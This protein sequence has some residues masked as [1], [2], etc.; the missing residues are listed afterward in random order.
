MSRW[1]FWSAL[2]LLIIVYGIFAVSLFIT[3]SLLW[4]G[5]AYCWVF[6][7]LI[8]W[9][10]EYK[11]LRGK[12]I[13]PWL[14]LIGIALQLFLLWSSRETSIAM[15]ISIIALAFL[16]RDL[17]SYFTNTRKIVWFTY[18]TQTGYLFTMISVFLFWFALLGMSQNFPFNCDQI[19]AINTKVTS[20]PVFA[21]TSQSNVSSL[22]QQDLLSSDSSIWSLRIG[23]K[24]RVET[25]LIST[26]KNIND[27]IC[28]VVVRELEKVYHNPIFKFA[29]IFAFYLLF[30]SI[31]R[32]FVRIITLF[33]YVIFL[34]LRVFGRYP[35]QNTLQQVEEIL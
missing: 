17:H 2:M 6:F 16:H 7:A 32:I 13:L 27:Q 1:R 8:F 15:R 5:L 20:L 18:F 28:Q 12:S 11:N 35:T 33:A 31:I 21:S 9:S 3:K 10:I 4:W 14:I 25:G 30:Y 29:V 24:E 26:Q 22:S 19:R 34:I 23:I